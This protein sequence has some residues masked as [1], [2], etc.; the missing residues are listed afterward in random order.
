ME[1]RRLDAKKANGS[2]KVVGSSP[3]ADKGFFHEISAEIN[4][5]QSLLCVIVWIALLDVL[6]DKH[7][8]K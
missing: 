1:C 7:L 5:C 8:Y 4:L 6:E 2:R 3:F